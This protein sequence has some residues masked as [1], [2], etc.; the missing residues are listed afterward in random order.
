MVC[1]GPNNQRYVG[2]LLDDS[3]ATPLDLPARCAPRTCTLNAVPGCLEKKKGAR[4]S[5]GRAPSTTPQNGQQTALL[6]Y[7]FGRAD[8]GR[9]TLNLFHSFF[10]GVQSIDTVRGTATR[11]N[12]PS[13]S[14]GWP[15]WLLFVTF[16]FVLLLR[17][18][19]RHLFVVVSC[20]K[21]TPTP[22]IVFSADF[23][24]SEEDAPHP[25]G[26]FRRSPRCYLDRRGLLEEFHVYSRLPSC[27]G[28]SRSVR[29]VL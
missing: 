13:R 14:L 20:E 15:E 3:G 2:R 23:R 27:Y 25:F 21:G 18:T 22:I 29:R 24:P 10:L 7:T 12:S 1:G 5:T 19:V 17:G 16:A 11:Q 26:Q 8:I 9:S 28:V 6:P 4:K